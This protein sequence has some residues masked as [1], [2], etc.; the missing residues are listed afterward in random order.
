MISH[1]LHITVHSPRHVGFAPDTG[2]DLG[3]GILD[4]VFP[5]VSTRGSLDVV[6]PNRMSCLHLL[7]VHKKIRHSYLYGTI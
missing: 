1:E 4:D 5:A 7:K 2:L 6:I 3:H